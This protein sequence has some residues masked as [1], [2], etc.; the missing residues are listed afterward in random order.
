MAGNIDWRDVRADFGGANQA[1]GQAQAGMSQAGTVFGQLRKDI[2]DA[3][4]R[5]VDNAFREKQL[6]EQIRQFG[7]TSGLEQDKFG[8]EQEKEST[9]QGEWKMDFDQKIIE[10]NADRQ[11]RE[12]VAKIGVGP[13]Y[14]NLAWAKE[15]DKLMREDNQA[16][17]DA[18]LYAN[19][20]SKGFDEE[21]NRIDTILRDNKNLTPDAHMELL[22]QRE[23]LSKKSA[24]A[25][26][27]S[28]KELLFLN[29]LAEGGRGHLASGIMSERAKEERTHARAI[30]VE[31]LKSNAKWTKT[32]QDNK[33]N[34]SKAAT[35][36]A[37]ILSGI[38]DGVIIGDAGTQARVAL[39]KAR[40]MG[41]SE[42][43]ILEAF[44]SFSTKDDNWFFDTPMQKAIQQFNNSNGTTGA[45]AESLGINT[46][47]ASKP[48]P[49]PSPAPTP[50][51]KSKEESSPIKMDAFTDIPT[52]RRNITSAYNI[53]PS[54]NAAERRIQQIEEQVRRAKARND[55][56]ENAAV[57]AIMREREQLLKQYNLK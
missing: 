50:E 13:A 43:K 12:N 20:A 34:E 37:K 3:E 19:N 28:G 10:N 32:L 21:K 42:Q 33:T 1:L 29:R 11:S 38:E 45:F 4:Q 16:I 5:S 54:K 27:E 36:T 24:I 46:T 18:T 48:T 47:P 14:A 41:V 6:N 23:E 39:T 57:Q 56:N 44:S 2:L 26:T 49:T 55:P 31:G 30:D 52:E 17:S 9:R 40:D 53:D 25:T 8:F 7:V 35:Q 51:S 15:K 22:A